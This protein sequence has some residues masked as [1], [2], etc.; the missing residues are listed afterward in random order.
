MECVKY[1]KIKLSQKVDMTVDDNRSL[2]REAA[3]V[4]HK[5]Q[6]LNTG[7]LLNLNKYLFTQRDSQLLLHIISLLCEKMYLIIGI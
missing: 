2:E 3:S 5:K 1:I 7:N 4:A 6:L